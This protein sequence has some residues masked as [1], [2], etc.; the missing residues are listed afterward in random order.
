M[1]KE[2]LNGTIARCWSDPV[3]LILAALCL[4]AMLGAWNYARSMP[5]IDYYVAWV[6]VDATRKDTEHDIYTSE[7]RFRPGRE[8]RREAPAEDPVSRK[9][10]AAQ[11][12]SYL[13]SSAT[14]FLYTVIGLFSADD[15]D[16]DLGVWLDWFR[17]LQVLVEMNAPVGRAGSTKV[18]N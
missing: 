10:A 1:N 8:Y 17:S 16:R 4:V 7:G 2:K 15:Y 14:P 9:A 13:H 6:V 12:V 3:A 11:F 18:V 5:G